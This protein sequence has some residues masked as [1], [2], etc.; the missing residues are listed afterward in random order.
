LSKFKLVRV[1]LG[2][3]QPVYCM[4]AALPVTK[5]NSVKISNGFELIFLFPYFYVLKVYYL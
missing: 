4:P 1:L 3:L 5:T 2:L